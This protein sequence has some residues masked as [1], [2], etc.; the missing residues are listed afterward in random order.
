ML[1]KS[2]LLPKF[3]VSHLVRIPP[4]AAMCTGTFSSLNTPTNASPKP[5]KPMHLF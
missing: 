2:H 4:E 1:E 5:L 3:I